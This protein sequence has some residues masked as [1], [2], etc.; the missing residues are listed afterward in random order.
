VVEKTPSGEEEQYLDI[1]LGNMERQKKRRLEVDEED[2][3]KEGLTM[4]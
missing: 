4:E 3:G 2:L 1:D